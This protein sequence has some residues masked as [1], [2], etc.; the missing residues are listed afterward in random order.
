MTHRDDLLKQGMYK[1]W[2]GPAAVDEVT[3]LATKFLELEDV[4]F[5]S[6]LPGESVA[7][8]SE[9]IEY[10][11]TNVIPEVTRSSAPP[12]AT[13]EPAQPPASRSRQ[14]SNRDALVRLAAA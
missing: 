1:L 9:R 14:R 13:R 11:A 3:R 7:S 2:D 6:Q 12:R 4:H 5:Y 10:I 8:G